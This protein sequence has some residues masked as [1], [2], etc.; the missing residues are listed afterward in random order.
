MSPL[1]LLVVEDDAANLEL[2]MELLFDAL[3]S[4]IGHRIWDPFAVDSTKGI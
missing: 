2:M 1:R 4:A 3:S